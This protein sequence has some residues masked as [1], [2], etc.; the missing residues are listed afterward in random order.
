MGFEEGNAVRDLERWMKTTEHPHYE[1]YF[2][3]GDQKPHCWSGPGT[4]IDRLK[5]MAQHIMRKK[6]E[7]A[8]TGWWAY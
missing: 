6:P 2:L 3:H 5:E 7:G 8:N 1:G 4:Q